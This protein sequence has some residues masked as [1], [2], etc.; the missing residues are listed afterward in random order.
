M[1]LFDHISNA[2]RS[3]GR[4]RGRSFLTML[5]IAIG[6]ASVVAIMALSAGVTRI[7]DHQVAELD[8]NLIVIRPGLVTGD[9]NS[10]TSPFAQSGFST[11][12]LTE[13]DVQRIS[14]IPGVEAAAPIMTIDGRLKGDTDTV[15]NNVVVA[16]TPEF[17]K[18]T[19]LPVQTGQFIDDITDKDTAVLG[20]QLAIDL[21]GTERPMGRTF[22][23]H[24]QRFT[25][26]GILK[27]MNN[28]INYN[29]IDFDHAAIVSM[30]AGKT[31]NQG[32]SQIQQI[33]VHVK[34]TQ[35][36]GSISNALTTSLTESHL[37]EKDFTISSGK[38]VAPP[39]S[40]IFTG[41]SA[42]LVAIA[43]IS[44]FV[45]GIGVMNI[46]LV[47]VAERTREIGIRKAVGASNASITWQFLMESLLISILGGIFGYFL[48]YVAAFVIST[49]LFF[50]PAFTPVSVIAAAVM[51]VGCGIIFGIYPALR[52][53]RKD[54]IESLRQYH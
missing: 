26:I 52:A 47:G 39:T 25:V 45:G 4:T 32:R 3:L 44:L 5:G 23:L 35:A 31:F 13:A 16:T 7:I 17:A 27:P 48:G 53:A 49:F 11:S 20:S 50:S 14:A 19:K 1:M 30:T 21:F 29:T 9:P 12:T 46:M 37:G 33:N 42:V 38:D 10:L 18:I 34:D 36:I 2:R 40:R 24:N 15:T 43:G 22:T 28:P 6:V 41:L 51:S 8:G 54:T